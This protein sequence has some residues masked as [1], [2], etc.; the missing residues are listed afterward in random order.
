LLLLLL[1]QVGWMT[2]PA[3]LLAPIIKAHQFVV[4]TVASNLQHAVAYGLDEA[5]WFYK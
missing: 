1:L 3:H 5:D 2:G 4:F